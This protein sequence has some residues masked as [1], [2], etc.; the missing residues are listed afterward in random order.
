LELSRDKPAPTL[1]IDLA[2]R[3]PDRVVSTKIES[4]FALQNP[5]QTIT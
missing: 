4:A 2:N 5:H 3:H 1:D